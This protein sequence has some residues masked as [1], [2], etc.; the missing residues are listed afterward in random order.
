MYRDVQYYFCKFIMHSLASTPHSTRA[1]QNGNSQA[2][3]I[4]AALAFERND[5]ALEIERVGNELRIRPAARKLTGTLKLF[6]KFPAQ[7]LAESRENQEQAE[8]DA[9]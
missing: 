1:F 2:V 8:R 5:I 3:R 4:P 6:A 9:L 7:F